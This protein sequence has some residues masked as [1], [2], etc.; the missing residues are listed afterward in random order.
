L[1]WAA[2]KIVM[3]EETA[4]KKTRAKKIC[5]NIV[6]V[7]VFFET[8]QKPEHLLSRYRTYLPTGPGRRQSAT[9]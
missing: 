3:R 6:F 7:L 1:R 5:R 9:K 2:A 8:D 4:T